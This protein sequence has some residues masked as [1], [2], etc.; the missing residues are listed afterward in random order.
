MKPC[1]GLLQIRRPFVASTT[2]WPHPPSPP[3]QNASTS[4]WNPGSRTTRLWSSTTT[5]TS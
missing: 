3:R 5:L 1:C 2:T 4:T